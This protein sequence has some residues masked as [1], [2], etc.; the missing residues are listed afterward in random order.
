MNWNALAPG[1]LTQRR[2]VLR[3]AD[4]T[5]EGSRV[6]TYA[7]MRALQFSLVIMTCASCIAS[8]G[9][10]DGVMGYCEPVVVT[11]W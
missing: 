6:K 5:S 1:P 11:H 8:D 4:A 2:G 3:R 7:V 9:P 10:R